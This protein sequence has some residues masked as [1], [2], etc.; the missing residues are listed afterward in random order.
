MRAWW[1]RRYIRRG[2]KRAQLDSR[3][4]GGYCD[5]RPAHKQVKWTA[6]VDGARFGQS[7]MRHVGALLVDAQRKGEARIEP[8]E[9]EPSRMAPIIQE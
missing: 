7:C 4:L 5:Y 2:T 9:P 8:V 3:L 6:T 1:L